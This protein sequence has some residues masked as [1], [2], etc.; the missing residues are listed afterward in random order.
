M[1]GIAGIRAPQPTREIHELLD[2]LVHRG[3][4]DAGDAHKNGWHMGMRRL[5]VI[6][7]AGGHQPMTSADGR[8]LLVMNGEIYNFTDLRPRL[9]AAGAKFRTDSDTE[10]LLEAI[11]HWGFPAAVE[12]A[13]GM[14]AIAAVEIDSG[15]LW[16]ARDR[17]GEK[18]LFLDRRGGGFAFA[19]EITPLL[20]RVLP[21]HVDVN[22]TALLL[23]LGYPWP[24]TTAVQGITELQPASW[25]RVRNSGQETT[26]KYW[27]PP[28]RV[29][30]QCGDV[31]RCEEK[32]LELLDHS[33]RQRL[34]ADVP[35]GLFLS[36]GIDSGAVAA[37]A[38]KVRKVEAVTVGFGNEEYDERPLARATASRSGI[39]LHEET[40]SLDAFTTETFDDYIRHY[41]QP[42]ADTSAF[43]TRSVSRRARAH[44]TVVLSGDGGDELLGGYL[45]HVRMTKLQRYGGGA[46]GA[47]LSHLLASLFQGEGADRYGRALRING[48]MGD[49]SVL[50]AMAGVFDDPTI[51]SLTGE[52]TKVALAAAKQE[53]R[54]HWQGS[55][56]PI[57]GLSLHQLKTS[58]PQD[59]LMKVDRMSMAESLEVRAPM[60]DSK[61]AAYALALPAHIKIRGG[62]GKAVL[63]DALRPRL[64]QEVLSAPKRGFAM[65]VREWL[66]PEFWQQLKSM[67]V[68]Y[69]G[70]SA[71]EFD[72]NTLSHVIHQDHHTCLRKYSY[73]ALHRAVLLYSFLRWREK[74]IIGKPLEARA[75]A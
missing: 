44:Y 40:G 43:P 55:T 48:A 39:A 69:H 70:D 51:E 64:P 31:R 50:W 47:Q 5:A 45:A 33:V 11:A 75:R 23:R 41:G 14:F 19:S 54:S 66:T 17:F 56:D 29:D 22:A 4:D 20:E 6:D 72:G 15:D 52:T 35:L 9:Q 60:L 28:D 59:I 18:P 46:I 74:W 13:E 37:S 53:M 26:G 68:A 8:W 36:G 57:L 42:F 16:L 63:R 7:V 24:G 21:R 30:E 38:A 65:P 67:A 49:G 61:F 1:C 34:V 2:R 3:P 73:R 58:M 27:T 12:A 10:V 32:L 25:L 62:L 71:A